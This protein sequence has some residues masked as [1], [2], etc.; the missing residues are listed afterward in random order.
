MGKIGKTSALILTIIIV[1]SSLII[2]DWIPLGLAQSGTNEGGIL[3]ANT[4]WTKNNSHIRY[5]AM[6]L[7]RMVL[8]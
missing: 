7:F 4:T 5:P 2:F 1:M 6:S 8:P 3:T